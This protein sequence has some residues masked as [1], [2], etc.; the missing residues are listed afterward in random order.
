MGSRDSL[1]KT[2]RCPACGTWGAAKSFWKVKCRNNSCKKFDAAYAAAYQQSR[3]IGKPATQVFTHLK[4]EADPA[5]YSLLIRY[6]N[7]RSDDLTYSAD[8]STAYR[9]GDHVVVRLAPAG[10]R[11]AFKLSSIQSSAEVEAVL[12]RN[13]QPSSHER[14][15]LNYHLRRGSSSARFEELRRKFLNYRG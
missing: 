9:Q 8:P 15:I 11:I 4:G 10:R 1:T 3:A 14:R 13:P 7:F 12:A 2:V 6:K 5:D